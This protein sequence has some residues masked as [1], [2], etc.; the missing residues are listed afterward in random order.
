MSFMKKGKTGV[1]FCILLSQLLIGCLQAR[2]AVIVP[3][4]APASAPQADIVPTTAENLGASDALSLLKDKIIGLNAASFDTPSSWTEKRQSLIDGINAAIGEVGKGA[5][6]DTLTVLASDLQDGIEGSVTG[7]NQTMLRQ[8]ITVVRESI[9]NASKTTLTI[10]SGKIAG[11][12][13]YMNSWTWKGI[14]Y[15]KPPVGDLR[16]RAPADPE[17]WNDVKHS[18]DSYDVSVQ[19][20]QSRMWLP[21]GRA[22]SCR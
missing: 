16:W 12:A 8:I 4:A 18:S 19:K 2:Q 6:A 21:T 22:T 3:P 10:K 1:L 14:P 20:E 9:D 13:G 17:P 5:Y 7:D 11:A 15:A